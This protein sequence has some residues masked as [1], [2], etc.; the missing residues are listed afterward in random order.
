MTTDVSEL[1]GM[2]NDSLY[3]EY[4]EEMIAWLDEPLS[5]EYFDVITDDDNELPF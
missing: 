1:T 5:S 4:V 3:S 2:D